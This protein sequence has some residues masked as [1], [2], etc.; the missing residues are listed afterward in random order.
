MDMSFYWINNIIEQGHFRVF[1]RPGPETLG[2]YNSKHHP[3][4]HHIA[5]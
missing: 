3:P 5:F 2:D 1:W 4:E